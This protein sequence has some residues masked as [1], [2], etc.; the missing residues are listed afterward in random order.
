MYT[1]IVYSYLFLDLFLYCFCQY[2]FY[3]NPNLIQLI[4]ELK[5]PLK[6]LVQVSV[7]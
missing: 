1:A 5:Y 3:C 4:F 7:N 2:R 6:I